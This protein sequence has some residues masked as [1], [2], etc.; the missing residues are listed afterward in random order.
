MSTTVPKRRER[1]AFAAAAAVIAGLMAL[2]AL[3]G[4]A[5]S[6]RKS[7]EFVPAAVTALKD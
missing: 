3:G 7:V 2:V 5:V 4:S 1:I 6:T